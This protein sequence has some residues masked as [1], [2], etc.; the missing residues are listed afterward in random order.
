MFFTSIKYHSHYYCYL[1]N[2]LLLIDVT[3]ESVVLVSKQDV[4]NIQTINRYKDKEVTEVKLLLKLKYLVNNYLLNTIED[5]TNLIIKYT[6]LH[7][8][9]NL[10]D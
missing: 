2:E 4:F 10:G 9:L 5:S 6:N 1:D 3:K 7:K 8:V